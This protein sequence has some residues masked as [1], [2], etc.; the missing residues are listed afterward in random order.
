[1]IYTYMWRKLKEDRFSMDNFWVGSHTNVFILLATMIAWPASHSKYHFR[2]DPRPAFWGTRGLSNMLHIPVALRMWVHTW[3]TT[4][5]G[6]CW[7]CHW[8]RWLW[9]R[10]GR[11][12]WLGW[13]S[14]QMWGRDRWAH[15]WVWC[16][17]TLWRIMPPYV[18]VGMML[19][20]KIYRGGWEWWGMS[21]ALCGSCVWPRWT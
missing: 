5:S 4:T 8:Q 14:C 7:W 9:F 11:T 13:T 12:T 1:M 17:C 2:R 6:G 21:S 16:I 3:L 10:Q 18:D 15:M 20:G 19:W